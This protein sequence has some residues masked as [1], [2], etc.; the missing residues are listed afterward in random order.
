MKQMM[1]SFEA[2]KEKKNAKK[3]NKRGKM[4]QNKLK[5]RNK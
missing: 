5:I 1:D 2:Q 3:L 4:E